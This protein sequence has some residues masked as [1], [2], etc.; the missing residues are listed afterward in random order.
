[1]FA[2]PIGRHSPDGSILPALTNSRK[3]IMVAFAFHARQRYLCFVAAGHAPAFCTHPTRTMIASFRRIARNPKTQESRIRYVAMAFHAAAWVVSLPQRLFGRGP[4]PLP[5]R[6][7]ILLIRVDGVGDLVMSAGLFGALR[8]AYPDARIDLLTSDRSVA[9][10]RMFEKSGDVNTVYAVP[11]GTLPWHLFRRTVALLRRNHYD[12]AVDLRGDFRN[13][14]MMWLAG[15]PRRYG[16]AYT[17]MNYLLTEMIESDQTHQAEE[18]AR[19]GELL[20]VKAAQPALP[21]TADLAAWAEQWLQCNGRD[22]SRPLVALHLTAGVPARVWP[23]ERFLEVARILR[24]RRRAQFL[25]LGSPADRADADHFFAAAD[26]PPLMAAGVAS[27]PQSAALSAQSD[28]F[29]GSDSGPGHIAAA[30]GCP[31]VVLFGP[32]NVCVMRPY[33]P[34][35]RIVK[36]PR[37]CD[38]RCHNK[39]CAVPEMHCLKAI[40]AEDVVAAAESLL[41]ERRG[42]EESPAK[43]HTASSPESA[44]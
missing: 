43:S 19:L 30:V 42:A 23:L 31:V 7:R 4:G 36:S 29:I 20:G 44:V 40:T 1:M 3:R 39:I 16:I 27:L 35:L 9:L 15:I 21:I 6:P 2:E 41:D 38:P 26:E 11:L 10:G 5:E 37:A 33:T 13:V 18:T 14:L 12:A 24:Q 22:R 17:A 25:V 34:L 8:A 28:L 32:G